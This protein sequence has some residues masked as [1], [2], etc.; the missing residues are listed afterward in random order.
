MSRAAGLLACLLC[1]ALAAPAQGIVG[2]TPAQRSA[3]PFFAVVGTG[4]GGALVAPDRVLTAAHCTEAL[5]ESNLV[6]V[7]PRALR[8]T[9]RLR[10]INPLHFRELQKMEREFPP[11]AADLMLLQL[12]RPV[13]GIAP[14]RIATAAEGLTAP[15][16]AVTTIGR[17]ASSPS[18]GGEGV[19]RQ[20][21]VA[22][23]PASACPDELYTPLL[24]RWSL[25][26]RDP[27]MADPSYPGPF[28]SACFGDSGGPLLATGQAGTRLVG[29]VSWGPRC[30]EER[31]PEIY[32]NAV[33][34]RGFALAPK[35]VWAPQALGEPRIAGTPQVGRTVTCAVRWLV[36]PT[37]E[38]SY[39]FVLDGRQVAEGPRPRYRLRPAD[40]GKQLSC[41][42]GGATAGGRGGP[43]GLAP[44]RPVR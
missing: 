30:G 32:A 23:Q 9:I 33:A 29:V 8:R 24:R 39:S 35:P 28:V 27:R 41:G 2:G 12:D 37:R 42:A 31:D 36:R 11:P 3:F 10:A 17:G 18:G 44:E 16:T 43:A 5:N 14:L 6:R 1:L 19:F 40:R 15:G 26:T 20:G 7:G 4:C 22:V 34:G 38:L 13:R 21:T 25:C